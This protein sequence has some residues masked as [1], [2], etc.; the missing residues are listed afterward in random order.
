MSVSTSGAERPA[1][2][3]AP[4]RAATL[5][6]RTTR[7]T[8]LAILVVAVAY[9][10][11][12][13]LGLLLAIPP[14]YATAVWP[15]SGIALAALLFVGPRV[16]PGVWLGS[17]LV[18]LSTG[19]YASAPLTAAALLL[20]A[21]IGVGATLQALAGAWLIRRSIG[22]PTRLDRERDIGKFLLLGG[23]VSCLL[24]ASLGTLMLGATGRI[25]WSAL[26][27][28]WWTWW[29][30]DSIGVAVFAPLLVAW[31]STDLM[32]RRRRVWLTLPLAVTFTLV[33][34]IFLLASRLEN[35]RV[36]SAIHGR[37]DDSAARLS[38]VLREHEQVLYSI[39]DLRAG[40]GELA[41]PR[42]AAFA[43][44]PLARHPALRA[45]AWAPAGAPAG[46]LPVATAEPA[47][48]FAG[49]DLAAS[50]LRREALERARTTGAPAAT[51][52]LPLAGAAPGASVM[53][54]YLPVAAE[55][56]V[57][58]YVAGAIDVDA[59]LA[60]VLDDAGTEAPAVELLDDGAGPGPTSASA[61]S[62]GE[63]HF[64]AKVAFGG[65]SF[66]V[67]YAATPAYLLAHRSWQAWY[68]LARGLLFTGLLGGFVL[69]LTGRS[70]RVEQVVAERLA[71]SETRFRVL[72][73]AAPDAMVIVQPDGR[74]GF[75]NAQA[76]WMFGYVRDELIGEPVAR[77]VPE[78]GAS[79]ELRGVRKDGSELP[80]EISLNPIDTPEGPLG[81][82]SIR[83]LSDRLRLE[84]ER[85]KSAELAEQNREILAAS[86]LKN[87]FLA[88]MSHELRTPL[89]GIIG[90]A[91]LM[92]DGKVGAVS[93]PHKEYLGD[94]LASS[95]HL[96]QLISDV[97][98][99]AKIEAGRLELRLENVDLPALAR[100][101]TE[102]LRGVAAKNRVIIRTHIDAELRAACTD[103]SKVKQILYN[104]LS[105]AIKFTDRGGSIDVTLARDGGARFRLAVE[106]TG[107]G[108][109]AEDLGK[110]FSEFQ[111]LDS[112]SNK[113]YAG[114]GLGLALTKRFAEALGGE[115]GVESQ[116]GKGSTF[117]AL[118]PLTSPELRD[119][120]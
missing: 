78:L 1:T 119:G 32:W 96:L 53:E 80:I 20:P 39:A 36:L 17:F 13:R 11:V 42:F 15:A 113:R 38:E 117:Y 93:A 16:A 81:I 23:P 57:I 82:A 14:G 74:I 52:R 120:R 4:P 34:A 103:A 114:T 107:I 116:V 56:A 30:G 64:D 84:R 3:S 37:A 51:A 40:E 89:N 109:R 48:A 71:E 29:V 73:E 60:G 46:G 79:G 10:V 68:V 63:I 99:L 31:W 22:F 19:L 75:V 100:E 110:L 49:V 18:N 27:F 112:G 97:L 106:D 41:P 65:R 94:I 5:P 2:F 62:A 61:V 69:V 111:Q 76:E 50:P 44:G 102:V 105:N 35:E 66:R 118:L 47:G 28:S 9:L 70:A 25:A 88:N 101:V 85:R 24:G 83:D 54:L 91:E 77:L 12:G 104:Y 72:I 6:A 33:L 43:A 115:V 95:Y 92:H 7:P 86:R 67:R 45:L 87:E 59:L 8:W 108:V 55:G 26:P 98:D 58:G 21:G 90:F